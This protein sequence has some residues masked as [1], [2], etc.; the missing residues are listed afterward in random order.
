MKA[1]LLIFSLV[2]IHAGC[3]D[4]NWKKLNEFQQFLI[5][6]KIDVEKLIM[7]TLHVVGN[8]TGLTSDELSDEIDNLP[9]PWESSSWAGTNC[10]FGFPTRDILKELFLINLRTL[11]EPVMKRVEYLRKRFV[12]VS[13]SLKLLGTIADLK[14]RSCSISS[15]DCPQKIDS[16]IEDNV[17]ALKC[18][19]VKNCQKHIITK[20]SIDNS[21]TA[22]QFKCGSGECT[23]IDN[24]CTG[25]KTCRDGSDEGPQ[26]TR[27]CFNG[28]H[29]RSLKCIDKL[30]VCNGKDDCGDNS[31]ETDCILRPKYSSSN[32][33]LDLGQFLCKN[34]QCI[35]LA[36]VCDG[37]DGCGDGSDEGGMCGIGCPGRCEDLSGV[38]LTTPQGP[39]CVSKCPPGS[40]DTASGCK[41][42]PEILPS[43]VEELVEEMPRIVSK[44]ISSVYQL[45]QAT[46]SSIF[47]AST[48]FTQCV[49]DKSFNKIIKLTKFNETDDSNSAIENRISGLIKAS[50]SRD[51]DIAPIIDAILQRAKL[52]LGKNNTGHK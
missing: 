36:E 16:W 23:S 29:C 10:S 47:K 45:K 31:D 17:S 33:N 39:I 52:E 11:E 5:D 43:T 18:K 24:V 49:G 35:P 22:N 3:D 27:Y 14:N 44:Y 4:F 1:L 28:F 32:C 25:T 13:S 15:K 48:N 12:E 6:Y 50:L 7:S 38:C 26:C 8:S 19:L 51:A 30:L 42:P 46:F 34:E 2:I 21:C 9:M 40:V 20:R 37:A 41:P